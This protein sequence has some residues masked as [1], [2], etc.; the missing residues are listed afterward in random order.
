MVSPAQEARKDAPSSSSDDWTLDELR[1]SVASIADDLKKV[2]ET[3]GQAAKEQAQDGVKALRKGVRKQPALAMAIATAVGAVIAVVAVP[4]FGRRAPVSR[5]D[6]W[7]PSMPAVT[8]ADL[9][10]FAHNMQNSALRAANSVPLTSSLERLVD[11]VS[12]VEPGASLTSAIEKASGWIQKMLT[13]VKD[14]RPQ[15]GRSGRS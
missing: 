15:S 13:A 1:G 2:V 7:V 4:R 11:A 9:Y 6:A 8:R 12:K 14:G 3:R 5:W 10:D